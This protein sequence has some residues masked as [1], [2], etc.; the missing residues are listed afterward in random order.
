M[1]SPCDCLQVGDTALHVA[2]S[3]NHKRTVQ[4]LLESGADGTIRNTV[5]YH[6]NMHMPDVT[7]CQSSTIKLFAEAESNCYNSLSRHTLFTYSCIVILDKQNMDN[8]KA[9]AL[10]VC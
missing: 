6:P 1:C 5:G 2:A 10:E 9:L 8:S 4:L 3:L 7:C